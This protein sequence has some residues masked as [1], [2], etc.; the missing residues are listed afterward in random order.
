MLYITGDCHGTHHEDGFTRFS[1]RQFP[2]Q[3][4]LTRED[5]LL[6]CGDFG[7][8][9]DGSREEQ[10]WLRWLH[11]TRNWTALF[12]CGNHENFSLLNSYPVKPWRGGLVHQIAPNVL[13]LC[14]GHVFDLGLKIF[15][16][17]GAQSHDMQEILTPGPLL[18]QRKRYLDYRKIPYRVEG[19]T[20]WPEEMPSP[21]EYTSARTALEKAGWQVDL[22][23]TH[24]A[25][26]TLQ[27][28]FAP[29]Y[30]ENQ[31]TDFLD[32]IQTRLDY[33]Q[34]YCGHYHR[35][36]SCEEHR[37]RVLYRDIVPYP[38]T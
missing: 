15:V 30:P 26:T 6:I 7:L 25:P 13:H 23:A 9:W 11:E 10:W 3:R 21:A 12:I 34:W 32:E 22:V 19:V 37:F 35:Q 1:F 28:R 33:Q 16:M 17:G 2:Q 20:W 27:R 8:L 36:L 38:C 4:G 24:C 31:L 29:E 14:N 5:Y 18:E